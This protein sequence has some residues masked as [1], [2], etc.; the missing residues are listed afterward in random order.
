MGWQVSPQASGLKEGGRGCLAI[1]WKAGSVEKW[2]QLGI[3]GGA[4]AKELFTHTNL[5]DL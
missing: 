3:S 4:T 2:S 1:W 5:N